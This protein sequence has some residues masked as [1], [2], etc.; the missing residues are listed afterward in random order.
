P[1]EGKLDRAIRVTGGLTLVAL[2]IGIFDGLVQIAAFIGG[3][4]LMASGMIGYCFLYKLL[5]ISTKE[6]KKSK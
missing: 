3:M 2:G 1:N 4:I 5:N 6:K